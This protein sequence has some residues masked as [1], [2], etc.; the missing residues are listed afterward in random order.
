MPIDA[1]T[2]IN[3][4]TGAS[5]AARILKESTF[6]LQR[7]LLRASS[8]LRITSPEV[9]A[10]GLAQFS[11]LDAQIGRI[12][13]AQ[14]NV[15]NAVSFSQTQ[16]GVLQQAQSALSRLGELSILAQDPTKSSA[17]LANIQ[18]EFG[19]LQDFLGGLGGETFN[20]VALFS[21]SSQTVAA[22]GDAGQVVVDNVDL[23]AAGSS[24]G[25]GDVLSVSVSTPAN[26]ASA[27]DTI[28]T[29]IQNL[30]TERATVGA[31]IERLNITGENNSVLAQNLT[32]ASSRIKDANI[33][34][35]STQIAGY[36]VLVQSG[37]ATLKLINQASSSSLRLLA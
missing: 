15:A 14:S 8:G 6:S 31:S 34:T 3:G 32:A 13:A 22:D 17:D 18:Q 24:G 25:I 5:Q 12:D 28:Q 4:N 10:A 16:D 9:D 20:G 36:K 29:A 30:S 2:T 7:S 26:A 35:E 11:R 19:Q 37:V 21:G 1:I 33:A 23:A 27:L